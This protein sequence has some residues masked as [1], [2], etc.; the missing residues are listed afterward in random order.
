MKR[1]RAA[2]MF[3]L[4]LIAALAACRDR[5]EPKSDVDQISN[6]GPAAVMPH[7]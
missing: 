3:V 4:L 5:E 6:V 7:Q 2:T 1:S